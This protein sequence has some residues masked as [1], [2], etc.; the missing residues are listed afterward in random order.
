[1]TA[2]AARADLIGIGPQKTASS[3]L[4]RC[5]AEHPEIASAAAHNI[6]YFTVQYDRGPAW[7]ARQLDNGGRPGRRIDVSPGYFSS[8]LAAARIARDVPD[9]RIVCC[10]RD[11]IA[12]AFSHYWHEK[13]KNRLDFTFAECLTQDELFAAWVEPSFYTRHLDLW[14]EAVP[15]AQLLVLDYDRMCAD[16]ADTLARLYAFAGVDPAYRPSVLHSSV[17]RARGRP[18]RLLPAPLR[19]PLKTA[20]Q[21][22]GLGPVAHRV[23]RG[24]TH[25]LTG[26]EQER[27]AD[28]PPGTAH[29]L[30]AMF[31]DEIDALE[32]L[33]GRDLSAWR[34]ADLEMN[35][36]ADDR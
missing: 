30:R 35:A 13:K 2:D 3:W 17:N 5:L 22:A 10:L 26:A 19:R 9:A 34:H 25:R 36:M 20:L 33:L 28:L 27:L 14:R 4:H 18:R 11:P 32:P 31:A 1:M 24:V 15:Q 16:P 8:R 21:R 12:R 23:R 6:G 29:R 7:Y